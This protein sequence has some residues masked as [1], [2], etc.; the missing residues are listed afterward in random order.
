MCLYSFY[1]SLKANA[2]AV[3]LDWRKFN[4]RCWHYHYHYHYASLC[5]LQIFLCLTTHQSHFALLCLR[6]LY[7]VLLYLLLYKAI[8]LFSNRSLPYIKQRLDL[9]IRS[10]ESNVSNTELLFLAKLEFL[11]FSISVLQHTT[12]DYQARL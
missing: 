4:P 8:I 2:V 7:Q 12:D 10:V 11:G 1:R 6:I 9:V 3:L 5:L